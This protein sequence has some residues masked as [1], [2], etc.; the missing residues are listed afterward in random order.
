MKKLLLTALMA[1]AGS[2]L[3]LP[4]SAQMTGYANAGVGVFRLDPGGAAAQERVSL[5]SFEGSINSPIGSN[6]VVQTNLGLDHLDDGA[7]T[8]DRTQI[9][10]NV[11]MRNERWAAGAYLGGLDNALAEDSALIGGAEALFYTPSMTFSV[12]V[13]AGKY[14]D[15]EE[16]MWGATADIRLFL[17][18][19]MRLDAGIGYNEF[20]INDSNAPSL[21]LGGEW[22]FNDSPASLFAKVQYS[23]LDLSGAVDEQNAYRMLVGV[24]FDF[25]SPSLK[26][27]D[28]SGPSFKSAAGLDTAVGSLF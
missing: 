22:R 15:I 7:T 19:N 20:T 12:G 25:G 18:D 10:V 21:N 23:R 24:R 4:A 9:T 6:L 3:A 8:A 17:G 13:G 14:Y 28:R 11:G 2:M 1:A 5:E 26:A 27:R 16:D